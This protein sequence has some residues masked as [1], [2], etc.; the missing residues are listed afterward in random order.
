MKRPVAVYTLIILHLLI[1]VS[2]LA[3]GSMLMLK[4]DGSLLGMQE[5]WLKSS[6]FNNYLIPGITLFLLIGS[7]PLF[8]AFGL[9]MKPS[10]RVSPNLYPEK[11]WAWAF[12]IY[13]GIII[14]AWIIIQQVT[15][16]YFWLQPIVASMGLLIL[17]VTMLPTVIEYSE[18]LKK[19]AGK[20]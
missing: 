20:R 11:H 12:S 16:K 18:T 15:T 7:L 10:Y 8:T 3:G 1:G 5:E 17:I 9:L 6:P 4:P 14:I 2:A 13:C 19:D